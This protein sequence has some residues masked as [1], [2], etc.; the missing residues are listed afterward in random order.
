[1]KMA[2]KRTQA[3]VY[4]LHDF[5]PMSYCIYEFDALRLITK[6]F[7][8]T[9]GTPSL[10]AQLRAYGPYRLVEFPRVGAESTCGFSPSLLN[11]PP[12]RLLVDTPP[13]TLTQKF[14]NSRVDR[15]PSNL[16]VDRDIELVEVTNLE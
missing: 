9:R 4:S 5:F 3:E 2:I 12:Q 7:N 16:N 13:E 10:T 6:R 14:E 8:R 1:M 15:K 11:Q